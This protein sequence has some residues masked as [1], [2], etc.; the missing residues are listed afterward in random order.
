MK[1]TACRVASRQIVKDMGDYV[2]VREN[3]EPHPEGPIM[4]RTDDR[5]L[6]WATQDVWEYKAPPSTGPGDSNG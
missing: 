6:Y 4:V 2:I 5:T 3:L 1:W